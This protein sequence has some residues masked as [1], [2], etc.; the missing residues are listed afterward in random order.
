MTAIK[1]LRF[2]WTALDGTRYAVDDGG[3][4]ESIKACEI[5]KQVTGLICGPTP[6]SAEIRRKV[7]SGDLSLE[8]RTRIDL[9]QD[10][11]AIATEAL[12]RDKSTKEEQ[13]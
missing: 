5:A 6:S 10:V 4:G 3:L 12:L 7:Q 2:H 11:R 9:F 13:S 8:D 1:G